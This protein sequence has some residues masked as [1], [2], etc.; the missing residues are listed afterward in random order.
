MSNLWCCEAC[1]HEHE[2]PAVFSHGS[3]RCTA[4]SHVDRTHFDIMI[5]ELILEP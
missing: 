1:G 3:K 5:W 4:E 2:T